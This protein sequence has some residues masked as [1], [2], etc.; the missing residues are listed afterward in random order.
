MA[1]TVPAEWVCHAHGFV[2]DPDVHLGGLPSGYVHTHLYRLIS[3]Y[4]ALPRLIAFSGRFAEGLQKVCGR[5]A[6]GLRKMLLIFLSF[7][8][9]NNI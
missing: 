2:S 9:V 3:P 6:E 4:I 5:F 8:I 1:S 7:G